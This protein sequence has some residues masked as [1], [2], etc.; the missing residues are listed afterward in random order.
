MKKTIVLLTLVASFFYG[1]AQTVP[2]DISALAVFNIGSLNKKLDTKFKLDLDTSYEV[3]T[4]PE[5]I[6]LNAVK[7][8]RQMGLDMKRSALLYLVDAGEKQ[9]YDQVVVLPISNLQLFEQAVISRLEKASKMKRNERDG[10]KYF[11]YHHTNVVY[12][13]EV[14]VFQHTENYVQVEDR[15]YNSQ[16]F[17]EYN[18]VI[19]AINKEKAGL[20]A[21]E[22]PGNGMD[23]KETLTIIQQNSKH[24]E[25]EGDEEGVD[26][27][28]EVIEIEDAVEAV[29]DAD[30][31]DVE[32][33]EVFEVIDTDDA[34]DHYS[35]YQLKRKQPGIDYDN[36]PL[37]KAF[38]ENWKTKN[39]E[40]IINQNLKYELE[41]LK[42]NIDNLV[43]ATEFQDGVKE[44][45]N[46][47]SDAS[48][49]Y[50]AESSNSV[51]GMMLGYRYKRLMR[52]IPDQDIQEAFKGNYVFGN[53]N[54]K[55][56]A[57]EM[58]MINHLNEQFKDYNVM[59][60]KVVN[61]KFQYYLPKGTSAIYSS[62]ISPEKMWTTYMD[63]MKFSIEAEARPWN[64]SELLALD[65]LDIF[66]NKDMINNTLEGDFLYAMP[67]YQTHIE[68][69]PRSRYNPDTYEREEYIDKDTTVKAD[70]IMLATIKDKDQLMLLVDAFE[71]RGML[72]KRA[73][74]VYQTLEPKYN[75]ESEPGDFYIG[76]KE[77]V[78]IWTNHEKLATTYIQSGIP[79]GMRL[80]LEETKALSKPGTNFQL[81]QAFFDI[82]VSNRSLR[83]FR[84]YGLTTMPLGAF[85]DL[86]SV[87]TAVDM[88]SGTND[89]GE[90][91][92][93]MN[94]KL[95][96]DVNVL[97]ELIQS[98]KGN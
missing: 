2:A 14:A 10:Q 18:Q 64:Q 20:K 33:G 71:K 25:S 53:L 98:L 86:K 75:R 17:F 42:K 69:I 36:H 45:L 52:G 32:V 16:Y 58:T 54:F 61:P 88:H 56:D 41:N 89:N 90:I 87:I 34:H 11:N 97:Q 48:F 19:M 77:D 47:K 59:V 30:T 68:E 72:V 39:A 55:G 73:P 37:M 85:G 23:V 96:E 26:A 29:E 63:L 74:G 79:K 62:Y 67:G 1:S 6:L 24:L 49:W 46:S 84:R 81:S 7:S 31:D 66:I 94:L 93:V 43:P 22:Q 28:E 83:S 80:S 35:D 3:L 95:N 21:G 78:F 13:N 9:G 76:I 44:T 27:V 12:N 40:H 8:P 70:L 65:M 51:M 60:D 92:S 4:K 91:E 82:P 57:V 15:L 5:S 50:S 38:E